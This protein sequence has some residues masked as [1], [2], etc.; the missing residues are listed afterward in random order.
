MHF[1]RQPSWIVIHGLR[2]D[3]GWDDHSR[4]GCEDD[5]GKE[6]AD[7]ADDDDDNDD[8]GPDATIV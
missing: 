5:D 1:V 8:D 6:E 4:D 2:T 7:D 3:N